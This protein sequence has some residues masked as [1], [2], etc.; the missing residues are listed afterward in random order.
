MDR[1]AFDSM[2]D[3]IRET[4]KDVG[5]IKVSVAKLDGRIGVVEAYV[6][7][8]KAQKT[9]WVKWMIRIGVPALVGWLASK[10]HL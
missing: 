3:D 6:T 10:L 9:D 1:A 4:R 7:E 8:Q 2:H 5:E